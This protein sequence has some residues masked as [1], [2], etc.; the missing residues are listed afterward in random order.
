LGLALLA[1]VNVSYYF[2]TY[3]AD[4]EILKAGVYRSAQGSYEI[5]VAVSRY[6]ASLGTGS[7]VVIV[8]KPPA[9]YDT[10]LTRY[11]LGSPVP[12]A[13]VPDPEANAPMPEWSA[14]GA[15]FIFFRGSE[16]DQATMH[17]RYPGGRDG[18]FIGES[19]KLAFYTYTVAP[20]AF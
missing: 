9:P 18:I 10:E 4:P 20:A 19:G 1:W 5:Q 2:G 12:V 13:N 16:Q 11:L 7:T 14:K 6:V 17:A 3:H 8:G 15:T